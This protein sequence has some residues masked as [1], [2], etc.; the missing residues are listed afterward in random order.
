MSFKNWKRGLYRVE[1]QAIENSR[2]IY[3]TYKL[4][5][6]PINPWWARRQHPGWAAY[7]KKKE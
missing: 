3:G 6:K 5:R 1:N 7:H 4:P 2:H